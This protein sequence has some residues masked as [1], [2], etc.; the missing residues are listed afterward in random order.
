MMLNLARY[1][2]IIGT[3]ISQTVF[4][5]EVIGMEDEGSWITALPL[6]QSAGALSLQLLGIDSAYSLFVNALPLFVALSLDAFLNRG[7]LLV[8]LW[9]YAHS[10]CSCS[11]WAAREWRVSAVTLTCSPPF[12]VPPCWSTTVP[13]SSTPLPSSYFYHRLH[14]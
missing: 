13:S 8:N 9:M 5:S 1:Y 11:F 6:M 14:H 7:G 12:F 10:A 4:L 2:D 3:L